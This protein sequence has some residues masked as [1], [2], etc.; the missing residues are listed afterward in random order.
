LAND[1]FSSQNWRFAIGG[2]LQYRLNKST[3]FRLEVGHS[4]ESNQIFF[5]V[6][7]GF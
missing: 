5:S 1:K 3:G 6:G 2:G 4:N 7:R